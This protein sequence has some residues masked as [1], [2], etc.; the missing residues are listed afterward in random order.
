M[1]KNNAVYLPL[2]YIEID[3]PAIPVDDNWHSPHAKHNLYWSKRSSKLDLMSSLST[4]HILSNKHRVYWSKRSQQFP[5]LPFSTIV[6]N[7]KPKRKVYW[8]TE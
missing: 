6:R 2:F 3:N 4:L 8:N 5:T 7:G 1:M